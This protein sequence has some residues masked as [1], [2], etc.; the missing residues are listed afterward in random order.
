MER[1]RLLFRA[2]RRRRQLRALQDRTDALS[3]DA[4]IA[5]TTLRN[6]RV[7][8]PYFLDYYRSLGVDQFLMV[9]NGSTDGSREYLLEQDDVSLWHTEASYRRSRFGADWLG[10]LQMRY[11]HGHWCLTV[12]TDEFLVYPFCDTRP[13]SALTDWMDASGL[14]ALPTMLLDMYPKG[15]IA[16]QSYADGQ[17]PFK[18]ACWFDSGN[19]TIKKNPTY[20]NLFIQGGPRARTFFED[21][22][23]AAPALN[24]I[25][26]VRWNRRYVYRTSTHNLLP[27]GLN[28]AYET[29][30]GESISGCLLHAKFIGS[31]LSRA[32]EEAKREEHYAGA[33][34]YKA[35]AA[36]A[37]RD[38]LDLW[39][40]K[41]ERYL[42][43]RQLEIFG[44]VS[45]G[46]WA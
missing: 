17:D 39:N 37:Q 5:F 24:K 25:P 32:A 1:R 20:G 38:Q 41:S 7:R 36:V 21:Q 22:P 3:S 10:W 44:L 18:M 28:F 16:A 9:D 34:E 8:L 26:L 43:W 14:V 12:D 40:E 30:G 45:K 11:G 2:F 6:E 35:Y 4:I 15:P 19:Y 46:S 27:R 31:F 42:N 23:S 33:R 29:N 13:L